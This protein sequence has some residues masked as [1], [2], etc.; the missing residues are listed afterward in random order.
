M[1]SFQFQSGME[2]FP[3][4]FTPSLVMRIIK[5]YLKSLPFNSK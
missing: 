4:N 1:R 5:K 3:S 2:H